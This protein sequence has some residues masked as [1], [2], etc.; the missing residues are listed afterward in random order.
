MSTPNDEGVDLSHVMEEAPSNPNPILQ[1]IQPVKKQSHKKL[2]LLISVLL[3]LAVIQGL[4]LYY[5]RPPKQPERPKKST[6]QTNQTNTST[7]AKTIK[8]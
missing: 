3:I 6:N 4:I 5:S 8:K 7:N 2:I 1:N